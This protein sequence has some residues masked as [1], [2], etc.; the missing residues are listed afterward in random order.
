[1]QEQCR[2]LSEWRLNNPD[3]HKPS[4]VKKPRVPGRPTKS[5]QILTLVSQQ[6]AAKMQKY[7]RSAHVDNTNIADKATADQEQHLMSM[8]QSSVAKHFTTPPSQPLLIRKPLPNSY[9]LQSNWQGTM[10]QLNRRMNKST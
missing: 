8:V 9:P 5:K 3:A 4:Y 10:D 1:M 2:E 6:V 7:H